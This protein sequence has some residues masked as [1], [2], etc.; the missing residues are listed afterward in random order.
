MSSLLPEIWTGKEFYL[1]SA[2]PEKR[3]GHGRKSSVTE[4]ASAIVTNPSTHDVENVTLIETGPSTG[5]FSGLLQSFES[6]AMGASQSGFLDVLPGSSVELIYLDES[7]MV[8][9]DFLYARESVQGVLVAPPVADWLQPLEVSVFDSDSDLSPAVDTVKVELANLSNSSVGGRYFLVLQ[10]TGNQTG[11]FTSQVS[12]QSGNEGNA[13][14]RSCSNVDMVVLCK[15]DSDCLG[16]TCS[17]WI[18]GNAYNE[19]CL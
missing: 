5:I 9:Q 3:C 8:V 15:Q 18:I 16:S 2:R 4:N 11:I 19:S 12:A 14:L 10:E 17:D 1:S 7:G 6:T 13:G